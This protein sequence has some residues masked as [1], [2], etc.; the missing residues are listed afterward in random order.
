MDIL[1]PL[2]LLGTFV[3]ASVVLAVTP[4]PGVLFIVSQSLAYGR[5]RAFAAVAG[6]ALGNFG[7]A[8]GAAL[9]LAVLLAVSSLAFMLVKWLGAAYLVWLGVRML[10]GMT[11]GDSRAVIGATAPGERVSDTPHAARIGRD[12]F[13]VALANP[14]TTLFFGAF[15]PQ[16]VT[17][18]AAPVVAQTIA[19]GAAFVAIAAVTDT[20]YALTASAAQARLARAPRARR[21]GRLATGATL[22]GLGGFTAVGGGRS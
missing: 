3:T 2:P 21:A 11:A 18:G 15:L 9:G 5:P 22:I 1:P 8:L 14:K 4:G 7:N 16:F 12:A 13:L 6:V 19:L 20:L 17:A 10:R